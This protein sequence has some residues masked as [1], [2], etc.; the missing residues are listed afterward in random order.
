MN[1]ISRRLA[2]Q[3][4]GAMGMSAISCTAN[5]TQSDPLSIQ[6][7]VADQIVGPLSGITIHT[8]DAAA[9]RRFFQGGMGMTQGPLEISPTARRFGLDQDTMAMRTYLGPNTS[10]AAIGVRV[11]E[12]A[13]PTTAMLRPDH[14]ALLPGALSIGFPVKGI[15]ARAKIL[16]AYDFPAAAGVTDITLPRG[17]GTT[18]KVFESHHRAPDGVLCLCI[19]RAD[20]KPVGPIDTDSLNIGGPAYSG[21]IVSDAAAMEAMLVGVFGW[22]KR[23]DVV[24]SSSGPNGGL[25]LPVGQRFIFQQ[26]FAPGTDTRYLV[27]MQHLMNQRPVPAKLGLS[28]RGLGMLSFKTRRLDDVMARAQTRGITILAR[29]NRAA[30]RS[31]ILATPDGVPM[32]VTQV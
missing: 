1:M 26:Y 22:Q 18:Y 16:S 15:E 20:L 12:G 25:G 17:D 7:L 4:V 2:L 10:P 8:S 32:E 19:D 29:P 13:S 5:A 9:Y 24:L 30:G 11:I 27:I 31:A 14:D 28:Q 21:M 6:G 23:R 3:G